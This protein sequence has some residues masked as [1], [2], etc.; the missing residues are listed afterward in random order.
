MLGGRGLSWQAGEA[1]EIRAGDC[2]VYLPGRGAHTRAR[3]RAARR[4]RVRRAQRRRER[5]LPAPRDVVRRQPHGRLVARGD[6]RRRDA[7]RPRVAARPAPLPSEPAPRPPTIVNVEDVEAVTVERPRV[8]RTRRNLGRAA[9]SVTTG[10]QHVEVAPGKESA[11]PHCHSLEEE[12]FVILDGDGVLVLGDEETPFRAGHV[13]SRPAGTGVAHM[14]RAGPLG[15]HVSRVRDAP[16][17]RRL[18]LPPLEQDR[19]QGVRLVAGWSGSTTGTART[20][21]SAYGGTPSW[22]RRRP[23]PSCPK[24]RRSAASWR[25]TSRGGRSSRPGSSIRGGRGRTRRRPSRPSLRGAVVER[26]E[27]RRQVPDLVAIAR[28]VPDPAPADDRDAPVRP[29]C[30]AAAHARDARVRRRPSPRVR[31]SAPVRHGPPRFRRGGAGRV[32]VGPDRDRAAHARVHRRAPA[33]A[34][35]RADRAGQGVR[36]RP[37]P[38]RRRRQHLRRRGAVPGPDPSAARRPGG[39]RAQTGSACA[40]ESRRR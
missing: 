25:R 35:A 19:V 7:V 18:L 12:I 3:A 36:A 20:D 33:R 15:A 29:R 24:S 37:A 26:L 13:I 14:F 23:C 5:R 8:V 1:S 2:I 34:R 6:R 17:R 31:R 38:D 32:P 21:P 28:A 9:G 16:H 10:I 11:P 27:P 30:R 40:R 22:T 39:S 4:A